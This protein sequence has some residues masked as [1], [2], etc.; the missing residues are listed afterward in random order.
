MLATFCKSST[1]WV[2]YDAVKALIKT[3]E[4]VK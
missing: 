2:S 4:D 1:N 3:G